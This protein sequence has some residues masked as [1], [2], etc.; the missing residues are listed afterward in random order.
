[1]ILFFFFVQVLNYHSIFSLE[2]LNFHNA[3]LDHLLSFD[4]PFFHFLADLVI[5]LLVV[6]ILHDDFS[7][8][9]MKKFQ[10][11]LENECQGKM[12]ELKETL[13]LQLN[14]QNKEV[15]NFEKGSLSQAPIIISSQAMA[16]SQETIDKLQNN[17][18]EKYPNVKVDF[19]PINDDYLT[20][21]ETMMLAGEAPDV[22]HG[23]CGALLRGRRGQLLQ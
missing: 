23:R 20:K 13:I 7:L 17:T 22:H 19:E 6:Y 1:M 8:G 14:C 9:K 10:E 2:F 3:F 21:V 16:M 4:A 5:I 12:K 11:A 18:L 15:D